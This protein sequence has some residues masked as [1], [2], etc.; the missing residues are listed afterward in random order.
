MKNMAMKTRSLGKTEIDASEF[1]M[2]CWQI[3]DLS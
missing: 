2:G 1:C 3:G